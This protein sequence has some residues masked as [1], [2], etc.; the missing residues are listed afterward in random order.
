LRTLVVSDLHLGASSRADLLRRAELRAPLIER[1]RDG[2]D[3]LVIL[4]DVVELREVPVHRAAAAARPLLA[5]AGEALGPGGEIVLLA[6]NHDHALVGGFI[7]GRIGQE[8]PLGLAHDI[9]A[10]DAGPLARDLAAAAGPARLR[11]SYPGIWL[12]EDVYALHG[13]YLD[14]HST[15]P[16]IERLA[17]GAMARWIAPEPGDPATPDEYEAVLAP[18]YAWMHALA[19]R[20]RDGVLRAGARSSTR[21]WTTLAGSGRRERPLRAAAMMACYKAAVGAINA[22]GIGPVRPELSGAALRRGSLHG[23]G[24][25]LRRLRV[26]AAHVVFGHSHRS[27][28]WPGDAAAEWTAPTGA[29]LVNAGCWVYQPHFLTERPYASPYW[30]GT[31]V[32][33]DSDPAHPPRLE[34]LLGDRDHHDLRPPATGV[35]G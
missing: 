29:R 31:A 33:V 5:E 24:E 15:V 23:V 13:H 22:A 21:A 7:E 4:G 17:A 16:T 28:P 11:L 19:Q 25:V 6:G 8:A 2:I 14:L 9:D 34:R 1:L 26:D 32:I 27:G 20:S 12:R 18:L 35:P 10:G 30:P 3:R